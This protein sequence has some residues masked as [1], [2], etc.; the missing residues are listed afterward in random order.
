MLILQIQSRLI[1][2]QEKLFF[3]DFYGIIVSFYVIA[4]F[5]K[6]WCIIIPHQ[7]ILA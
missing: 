4:G 2:F 1:L 6:V 3:K 7:Q 5:A